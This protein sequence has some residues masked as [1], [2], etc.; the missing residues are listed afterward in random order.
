MS[1]SYDMKRF[2]FVL[3]AGRVL[4]LL[5]CFACGDDTA[6]SDASAG[7]TSEDVGATDTRVAS[8]ATTPADAGELGDAGMLDTVPVV[9]TGAATDAGTITLSTLKAFPTA[10]GAG[11]FVTG[12]RGGTTFFVN[13]RQ[14]LPSTDSAYGSY[15]EASDT[16][17]G[18]LRYC[19]VEH[20]TVAK[21]IVFLVGGEFSLTQGDLRVNN[22][23]GGSI[24][25]LGQT[26]RDIGGV[27]IT[28]SEFVI[29]FD[30]LDNLIIRFVDFKP[31][32]AFTDRAFTI[33]PGVSVRVDGTTY[34]ISSDRIRIGSRS[35]W[36]DGN[37]LVRELDGMNVS[38]SYDLMIDHV[39]AGWHG[40]ESFEVYAFN[41]DG[42]P[43]RNVTVQRSLFLP[44][45]RGHNVGGLF[46]GDASASPEAASLI[47]NGDFHH[48]C[49]VNL[50]HRF[51]NIGGGRNARLRVFNNVMY[52]WGS[53]LMNLYGDAQQDV[54]NN[55]Y[56]RN[57]STAAPSIRDDF[58][59]YK[60][61]FLYD[62]SGVL[63]PS[64]Y[65]AGNFVDGY[66]ET[67][68]ED[69]WRLL[70]HFRD[71]PRGGNEDP[72][73]REFRRETP[74]VDA[75]H[76][77]EFS[78]ACSALSNVLSDVGANVVFNTDGT[79]SQTDSVDAE[80]LRQVETTTGPTSLPSS[81]A[82]IYPAYINASVER[83][84]FDREGVPLGWTPPS[85][86]VNAAG[87]SDQEL[88]FAE[89]AGDFFRL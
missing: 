44:G 16:Y 83:S 26:A 89:Q 41:L 50:T 66:V 47:E 1:I 82:W 46:G 10:M 61:D 85:H 87:Y 40:D 67:P 12:G 69:N 32:R 68:D 31:G 43:F 74:I 20:N 38:R 71:S 8:D 57:P 78:D 81:E 55:Y 5:A 15:D 33:D 2:V 73:S 60:F 59:M 53:R 25:L 28:G 7:D 63:A 88:Y 64:I 29:A 45:I 51:P 56:R 79:T 30:N 62:P 23:Q 49:F 21:N 48:S 42:E 22:Q 11:M 52:G 18:T 76:P 84:G 34:P 17:S 19:L 37:N 6:Q 75:A 58:R 86:V 13:T 65:V 14:D 36:V 4:C 54:F 77:I 24:S 72:L 27:H 35:Y 9:D 3:S 39:T 80:Y 70:S